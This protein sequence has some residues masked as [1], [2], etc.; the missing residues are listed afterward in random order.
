MRHYTISDEDTELNT[1]VALLLQIND[2]NSSSES[3]AELIIDPWR[4]FCSSN[5]QLEG[6]W[7]VTGTSTYHSLEPTA[8]KRKPPKLSVPWFAEGN[9][10]TRPCRS[11]SSLGHLK[12]P[13]FSHRALRPKEIRLINI[14]P[15]TQQDQLQGVII[16]VQSTSAPT[17]QALSYVWGTDQQTKELVTPDGTLPISPSLSKALHSLRRKDQSITL[18]VDA[19][20]INQKDGREKEKQ[21]RLLPV[22]F[23]NA[24]ITYAFLEGGDG[25]DNALEMLMQ[26]RFKAA[27]EKRSR[28]YQ[29]LDSR[30]GM[31]T[32]EED[33]PDDL[34]KVPAS[35]H[36]NSIPHLDDDIWTHVKALFS[37]PFF[38][39]V[40]IV[41]EVVAALDVKIICGK[42]TIDWSDL[43]L[44]MEIV[45]W[46]VQLFDTDTTYLSSSW[47]PFFSLA[48]QREW[49]ARSHRR[50]LSTLLEHFRYTESTLSR[51]RL[52]AMLGLASDG[53]EADFEPDYNSPLE[54]VVLRFAR[55]FVRQGIGMQL[56]YRAGLHGHSHRFPS[57]IPDWT[58]QKPTSLATI[59][60][61]GITFR[62]SRPQQPMIKCSPDSDE[63]LVDG[64]TVD[65]I[66]NI[67]MSSNVEEGLALYFSEVDAMIDRA[68]LSPSQ[69]SR[70][71]LKWKVPIAKAL[72]PK[73]ATS[74]G[75][76][77]QSSYRALRNSLSE[78]GKG[79]S[80][81]KGVD[82]IDRNQ[83]LSYLAALKDTVRGWRF[84]VTKKGYVGTVPNLAQAGDVIAIMKGGRVP[85]ILQKSNTKS[86]TFRLVGECYVHG[87]MNGEGLS[88]PG[89]VETTFTLH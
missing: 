57:W 68:V 29:P 13:L 6:E 14:L 80:V 34:A 72:F 25:S 85:F 74:G 65:V 64:Y 22:I 31:E 30:E 59:S 67:S 43:H 60:E 28:L 16:H 84:V 11:V 39:R 37:L 54:E 19:I 73:V 86:G 58:T 76:D 12:R 3:S 21:I 33:W 89:V 15:G 48:A 75:V 27:I 56:L 9:L 51:D 10:A 69:T 23:Q 66:E 79:K 46:Q 38:R 41:Q 17:Y 5:L 2:V 71:D 77:L 53:N 32:E 87:L 18:W 49:E 61:T 1:D 36:D 40:W 35:W 63:L 7:L 81:D 52:F 4:L 26:V 44:A 50:S 88:L 82:F 24:S 20:C 47:E 83:G 42:R 8:K 55:V 78:K 62:A 45:D 70:E